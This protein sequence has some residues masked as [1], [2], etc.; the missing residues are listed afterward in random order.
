MRNA[1]LRI[2]PAGLASAMLLF[3]GGSFALGDTCSGLTGEQLELAKSIKAGTYCYDCC[4]ETVTKCLK[5]K[6]PCKLAQRLSNEI[7]SRAGKG[8][9]EDKIKSALE[10]RAKSMMPGAKTYKIDLSDLDTWVGEKPKVRV[11]AKVQ[12]Q[13]D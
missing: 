7:C 12:K 4:D 1:V 6:K 10:R 5:K 2:L 9:S 8:Q 11:K 13:L 3:S